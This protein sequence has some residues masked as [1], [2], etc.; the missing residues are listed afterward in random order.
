ML[1]QFCIY[2]AP[3]PGPA[4]LWSL[5]ALPALHES[6]ASSGA[7]CPHALF[8]TGLLVLSESSPADCHQVCTV[9]PLLDWCVVA[10]PGP[11]HVAVQT[12]QGWLR[13]L[14]PAGAY[15]GLL[16]GP[17]LLA[18]A[19]AATLAVLRAGDG[20]CPPMAELLLSVVKNLMLAHGYRAHLA[21]HLCVRAPLC[22][23]FCPFQTR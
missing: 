16:A 8:A 13:L 19:C 9:G 15:A 1:D 4:A 12:G 11:A 7:A 6:S 18:R 5:S 17:L 22:F 23:V 3:E 20:T 10:G 2:S 14:E 21:P